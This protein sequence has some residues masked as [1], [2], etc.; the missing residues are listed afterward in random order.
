MKTTSIR[1]LPSPTG[2]GRGKPT[3]EYKAWK[4]MKAR[5]YC[6]TN[7]AYRIYGG[8]GIKVCESWRNSFESFL[9]DMGNKPSSK[10][11]LERINNDGNYCKENCKWGT[12]AEQSANRSI[13]VRLRLGHK[14]QTITQWS[15]ELKISRHTIRHR[16]DR[17]WSEEQALQTL[18]WQH[19]IQGT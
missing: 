8:R 14:T 11:S 17:G 6:L 1:F 10:H 15:R 4:G 5:C 19:P 13:S 9:A 7:R 2:K 12:R 16:L 3:S 18:Q